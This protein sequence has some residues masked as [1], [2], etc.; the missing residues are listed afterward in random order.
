MKKG[1][2]GQI[3]VFLAIIMIGV[4]AL[5]GLLVDAAR[6]SAGRGLVKRAV[7]LAAGS[8]LADYSSKLK[9]DYGLFTMPIADKEMLND[10][11]NEYLACNLSI[12]LDEDY[13]KGSTDLFGFRIERIDV[14]PIYNLSENDITKRQILEHMKYRGPAGVVEEFIEKLTAVKDVGKMSNAYKQ[15]VG[16]DKILGSMDKSQQKLKKN[17]D[18]IGNDLEKFVNGFNIDSSWMSAFND[19]NS[20]SESLSAIEMNINSLNESIKGIE[21]QLATLDASVTDEDANES[22]DSKNGEDSESGDSKNGEEGKS[23]EGSRNYLKERLSSLKKERSQMSINKTNTRNLLNDLW[24]KIRNSMTSD[25]IKSNEIAQCEIAK[26]AERGKKAQ[27]AIKGLEKFLEDNFSDSGDISNEEST[28]SKDFKEQ[29]QTEL[30]TMKELILEGQKAEKML[31]NIGENISVLSGAVSEM[32]R[33]KNNSGELPDEGLPRELLDIIGGYTNIDYEYSKPDK[34]DKKDDP[35]KGKADEVK[36]FIYKKVLNEV[37][38][39]TVGIIKEDLPS[40]TKVKTASFDERDAEFGDILGTGTLK[41]GG[42][43]G[44]ASYNGNLEHVGEE[45]DLYDEE[46]VFQENALGLIS[47]IG[48][49]ISDQAVS[50]RDNIYINEYIMGTFK[51]SVSSLICGANT[52]KDVNLHGD[53]KEEIVTFYDSEVE[54]ILHGQASQK[55][56]NVLTK[57]ELMLVR[58]ALNTLHVYTDPAKKTKAASIATA[59]AGV[60]TGGAG[61]PVISN[62]IM[63]GWGI[64]EAVIDVIELMEGRSVPIYKMKGDWR[65][66]IGIASKAGPKTDQRLYF[67]YHDYLRLFLLT[68]S[69]EKKLSR[70]EDLIQL[71]IGKSRGDHASFRMSDCHTY[72]R[73]EAEVSMKYLFITQPFIRK[74]SKTGDGRYIYKVLLYEG[75]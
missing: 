46:G 68:V 50:L 34:G 28:F 33:I 72:V 7:D 41:T 26:I 60:W 8:L 63:C 39:E 62:L 1:I 30:D 16:I 31:E 10:W 17:I 48:S 53:E 52:V 22:G 69:E 45:V 59:V 35:R 24:Y 57:G 6:I 38:Y 65:L 21:S 55:L 66:D 44:E 73:I 11:F 74:E 5:A 71:N 9:D 40:Y 27:L 4:L 25:Y 49:I 15:K 54:Y 36:E 70:I 56:N 12:P 67:N 19:F 32:D 51:N 42:I 14:T 18:G 20:M 47:D 64:G 3:T 29:M 2:S 13:Y 58:I 43:V 37:N 75:Y 23:E 61:I